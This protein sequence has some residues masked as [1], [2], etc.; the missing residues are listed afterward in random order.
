MSPCLQ[1]ELIREVELLRKNTSRKTLRVP[2][3]IRLEIQRRLN[4]NLRS[5]D[6]V[7]QFAE[8]EAGEGASRLQNAVRFA[9][10]GWNIGAVA[11]PKCNCV[12]VKGVVG[13][14]RR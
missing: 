12:Q 8:L 4:V 9:E 11:Y 14:V 10:H 6:R 7:A 13:E 3:N 1:Q 2:A 5:K